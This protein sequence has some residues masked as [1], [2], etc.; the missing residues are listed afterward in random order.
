[1]SFLQQEGGEVA[2]KIPSNINSL[3]HMGDLGRPILRSSW[4]TLSDYLLTPSAC[5][6]ARGGTPRK[7]SPKVAQVAQGGLR[8]AANT[9]KSLFIYDCRLNGGRPRSPPIGPT[10][11]ALTP[12]S[13]RKFT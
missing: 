5:A 11:T 4:R 1:M 3:L 2:Q 7:R 10:I 12:P 13:V 9:L 6:C 8:S